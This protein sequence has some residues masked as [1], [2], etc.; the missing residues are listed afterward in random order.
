MRGFRVS[1]DGLQ[2]NRITILNVE[3]GVIP[4]L[5]RNLYAVRPIT[6][7]KIP[8]LH[9]VPLGMTPVTPGQSHLKFEEGGRND[10]PSLLQS[11]NAIA[12]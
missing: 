2:G 9:F 10:T 3:K 7:L 6:F 1:P 12:L 11:L 8:R 5:S 4:S